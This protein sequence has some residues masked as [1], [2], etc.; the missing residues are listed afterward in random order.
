MKKLI[1]ILALGFISNSFFS[2]TIK[3]NVTEVV[4]SFEADSVSSSLDELIDNQ[5]LPKTRV[6][7]NSSYEIDLT[8]KQFK[9][10]ANGILDFEG[11][12]AFSNAGNLYTVNFLIDGYITGMLINMDIRNE[13]V[14]WF[15]LFGEYQEISK[16]TRFEIVKGF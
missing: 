5:N 12:I 1:I 16:F 9:Y 6:Y 3:I 8:H 14:T 7:V 4:N 15:S 10:Y 2:Q 13:Q 11:E